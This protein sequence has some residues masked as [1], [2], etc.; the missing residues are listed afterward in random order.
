MSRSSD[1]RA[2]LLENI[3]QTAAE[4]G[5]P[6]STYEAEHEVDRFTKRSV[7]NHFD[8]WE[9]AM[10]AAGLDGSRPTTCRD[11]EADFGSSRAWKVHRTRIHGPD[12]PDVGLLE[13]IRILA[14]GDQP[15]TRYDM[16]DDGAY[17]PDVYLQVF[18]SWRKA[19]R[20]AGF[21]P[22]RDAHNRVSK[23]E[24]LSEMRRLA[25]ELG[26]PP[27]VS[28][29]SE[30]GR[31]SSRPYLR[32][33]GSWV[34]SQEAAGLPPT[35]A[36]P[37]EAEESSHVGAWEASRYDALV[38]D[39]ARCQDCGLTAPEHIEEC[40]RSLDVHHKVPYREFDEPAEA[41]E[42]SNLVTVCRSCHAIRHTPD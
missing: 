1:F 11:C 21:A 13:A 41:H 2:E 20:Q 26:H 29:M 34:A 40:G 37:G 35:R 42:L 8:S 36:S 7:Y 27:R 12:S 5:H 23:G 15:P 14:D 16:S 31:Y 17:S 22:G 9:E 32:E 30:H 3:R 24:L 10:A 4:L 39:Q 25:D 33:F 6:P 28:D 38:R 19:L 18:G